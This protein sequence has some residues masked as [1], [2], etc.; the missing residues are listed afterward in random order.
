M[1][2]QMLNGAT[3][4]A[5]RIV[6]LVRRRDLI[7][8]SPISTRRPRRIAMRIFVRLS[9]IFAKRA[10]VMSRSALSTPSL[11]VGSE[12]A[13]ASDLGQTLLKDAA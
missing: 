8:K 11:N 13:A 4:S 3:L 5:V 1:L 6:V 12:T 9:S 10:W 7:C 2:G